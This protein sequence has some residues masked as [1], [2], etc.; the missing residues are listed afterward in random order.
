MLFTPGAAP[1][2]IPALPPGAAR[3]VAVPA[4][5]GGRLVVPAGSKVT[6]RAGGREYT[7]RLTATGPGSRVTVLVPASSVA[8]AQQGQ[9]LPQPQQPAAA[10]GAAALG[11]QPRAF[12]TTTPLTVLQTSTPYNGGVVLGPSP[13]QQAT[14]LAP[15]PIPW[16]QSAPWV[17]S[18]PWTM[19]VAGTPP[20]TVLG[21]DV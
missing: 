12:V 17:Q 13:T 20:A 10:A 21:P 6:V 4:V 18:A 16:T 3:A 15:Q 5:P 8:A 14:V 9:Q 19:S 2:A 11:A 7:T 1:R